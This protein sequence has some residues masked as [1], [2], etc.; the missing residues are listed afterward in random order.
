MRA[1]RTLLS[2]GIAVP[3]LWIAALMAGAASRPACS[4]VTQ[5][6]GEHGG[7]RGPAVL[8]SGLAVSLWGAAM[9]LGGLFP[10]PDELHGGVDVVT[11]G[12]V[13]PWQRGNALVSIRWLGIVA[14][15]LRL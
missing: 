1:N 15:A 13:G 2:L 9:T 6:A 7:G 12:N 5:C 3:V 11:R 8:L 4:H 14:C 10:M